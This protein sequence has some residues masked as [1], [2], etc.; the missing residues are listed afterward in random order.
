MVNLS[1]LDFI[2]IFIY[3]FILLAVGYFTS[4]KQTT[5]DYLI[6]ER[7]LGVWSTMATTNASKTGS[8]LMIFVAMVYVFG[9][10]ALWYFIGMVVGIFI[11]L[12]FAL[13]LKDN[14]Q[15]RFY[16]LADYFKYNY[17]KNAAILASL[18]TIFL[19]FGFFVLNLIAGTKI[20]VFFTGWSFWICA[21]IMIFIVLLYL[22]MGG[23]KA[24]VKT[25][26]IQYAALVFI[27][28]MLTLLLFQGSIIPS[29]EWNFFNA[30]LVTIIGFFL[31]G[32]LLPFAMPD[33]WQRVYA[34]KNKSTLKKG[35]LLSV[36]FY[37]IV[38]LLLA[39]VALTIKVKF[40]GIDPDLALIYGFAN[41]LPPGLLG[42]SAVLLFAAVMSSLDTYLYTSSSAIVQDFFN[43]NKI[44]TVRNIR[45]VIFIVAIIGTIIG[46]LLHDLVIGSYI[47]VASSVILATV[48]ILTWMKKRVR[49]TTLIFGFVIGIIVYGIYLF[50]M[51]TNITPL[52]VIVALLG[53][54][55][56]LILGGIY[57]FFRY[58]KKQRVIIQTPQ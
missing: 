13:R 26:L 11:F 42:L 45:K 22:L 57:S 28:A 27:L 4:R 6:A 7:K 53:A 54:I 14:S 9:F 20:F 40:P 47:F 43:W 33:I 58:P 46:I 39:F 35:L 19:M 5:E 41:L 23:F 12:P 48:V 17:G 25:D 55:I 16:T 34:S 51:I 30:D 52:I 21:I 2:L 3:F 37:A 10:S 32:V 8:I 38:A 18:L 15:Q 1:N 50:F 31:V 44:K 56:G 49:R 36:L 24:V 29:G